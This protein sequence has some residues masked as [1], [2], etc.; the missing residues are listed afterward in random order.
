MT[1]VEWNDSRDLKEQ[2]IS[3]FAVIKENGKPHIRKS[4][5]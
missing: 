4:H 2:P 5:G 3:D 1:K